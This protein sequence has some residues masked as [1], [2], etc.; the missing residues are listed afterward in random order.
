MR[1][2]SARLII[3]SCTV[4]VGLLFAYFGQEL[5]NRITSDDVHV[6]MWYERHAP[7]GSVRLNLAPSAPDR[8]TARYPSVTL[9]D[10]DALVEHPEF[11][12]HRLGTADVPRV[13]SLIRGLG[14]HRTFVAL[15]RGQEGYARLNGLL[16][17]RSVAGLSRALR[18][19][20]DFHLVYRRPTA[21]IFEYAPQRR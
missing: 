21:W 8:L 3:A 15:S 18:A 4:G 6:A 11:T 19:S 9:G 5:A 13:R 2:S 14:P 12:G 1:I 16:P 17:S 7:P 10:P 20:P